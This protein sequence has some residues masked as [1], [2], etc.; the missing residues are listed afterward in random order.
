MC[1]FSGI[2]RTHGESREFTQDSIKDKKEHKLP[3]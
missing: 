2:L 1:K 3:I